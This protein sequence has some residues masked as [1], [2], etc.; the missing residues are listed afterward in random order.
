MN[1]LRCLTQGLRISFDRMEMEVEAEVSACLGSLHAVPMECEDP[2]D[3]ESVE[4]SLSPSG[5]LNRL[6]NLLLRTSMAH[7]LIRNTL[8]VHGQGRT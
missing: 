8:I 3:P 7:H 2:L 5:R 4:D 6:L 1:S